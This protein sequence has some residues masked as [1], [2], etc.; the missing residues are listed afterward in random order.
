MN[1]KAFFFP[2]LL[3]GMM[4]A[5]CASSEEGLR[6]EKTP[7]TAA[8][9]GKYPVSFNVYADR[10]VTRSGQTGL[11]DL[12]ALQAAKGDVDTDGGGFG[13]F[14][15]YTDLKKYDQTYV[16]NF[17]YNQGVF[18]EGGQWTYSPVMYWPNESGSGAQSDDEDKVSFFAYAPYVFHTSA[19][20]GSVKNATSGI[21]GFSRNSNAGDPLVKYIANF[22][23]ANTVDL[24]WG[25]CND[26]SWAKIQ[27]GSSQSMTT[28]LP[29]LDVEHPQTTSQKMKFTFKHALAQLNVQIDADADVTEHIDGTGADQIASSTKIYVRSISF[30]GIAMKGALNLNN[31]VANQALWLDYAGTT[32]LPYGESVTVKDG[33]RDGREGTS[34]AEATNESPVGLNPEIIQNSTATTGVTTTY[35]NLFAPSGT[36]ADPENPTDEELANRLKEPVYVIPTG[37]AMT[38]TIVYD[39]ETENPSLT[40]YLSDGVTHGSS[41]ENKI[42]KTIYYGGD[43]LSLESGKKYTIKLH[44]CMNSVK[45]D[46]AVDDWDNTVVNA[47]GWLPENV[48]AVRIMNNSN[49]ITHATMSTSDADLTLTGDVHPS[50]VAQTLTWTSSDPAVASIADATVGTIHPENDGECTITATSTATGKSASVKLLVTHKYSEVVAGDVRKIIA[51]N[52]YIYENT[53]QAKEYGTNGVGLICYA[54]DAGS[55]DKSTSTDP[56]CANYKALALAL[57]DANGGATCQ[58]Y[59]SNS[60]TC[61]TQQSNIATIYGDPATY[62]NGIA[63]TATLIAD[64]DEH[65]AAT[66]ASSYNDVCFDAS[67][68]A[69]SAW[70]LPSIEQWDLMIR[71]LA[72]TDS[73]DH[74]YEGQTSGGWKNDGTDKHIP[75][76]GYVNDDYTAAVLNPFITASG[77]TGL[78]SFP[79]WSSTEYTADYAWSVVFNY[80]TVHH[81]PKANLRYVRSVFAF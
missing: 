59:T 51:A 1:K 67:F 22:N 42:T 62:R 28:G 37:E 21:T 71:T 45:F 61:L 74:Y 60:G 68:T 13:V 27:G 4:L 23:T 63:N 38:V 17:M 49:Q 7:E 43:G 24:C 81:H 10:G 3:A 65:A 14:A 44:L 6:T 5:S 40:G 55:A 33:R 31:T 47:S 64:G 35:Q 2:A 77:A 56:Q 76:W 54:G 8:Q 53:T 15:Y 79:Y 16:P 58:W 69:H 12:S 20:S 80:C 36:I 78:Q 25:V 48:S 30:T 70:F 73:E 29:W 46:A 34:G 52:G 57:T 41:I 75:R 19:A 50:G 9:D 26:P 66:A 39:V 11:T 72:P 32:D 18:Y